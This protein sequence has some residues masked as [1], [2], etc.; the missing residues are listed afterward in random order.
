MY[1]SLTRRFR[2]RRRAAFGA[3]R[4]MLQ[5]VAAS[6]PARRSP[7]ERRARGRSALVGGV[8]DGLVERFEDDA[9]GDGA[10]RVDQAVENGQQQRENA[11]ARTARS[12]PCGARRLISSSSLVSTM[13]R[14]STPDGHQEHGDQAQRQRH[15]PAE[16]RSPAAPAAFRPGKPGRT[17]PPPRRRYCR[18]ARRWTARCSAGRHSPAPSP[19]LIRGRTR[20]DR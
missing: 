8:G 2:R 3:S 13:P 6:R 10:R 12:P 17:A 18:W 9:V 5:L 19:N 11:A 15:F 1:A 14:I 20:A 16:Q 7:R 4:G